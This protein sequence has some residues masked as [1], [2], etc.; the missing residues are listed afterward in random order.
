MKTVIPITA[1]FLDIGGVLSTNECDGQARKLAAKTCRRFVTG[2][3]TRIG[4]IPNQRQEKEENGP[5]PV[6]ASYHKK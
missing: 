2:N 4:T 5:K 6:A 1:L 3:G